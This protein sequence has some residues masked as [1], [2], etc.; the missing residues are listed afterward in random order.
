MVL[1][2]RSVLGTST[3]Y[4]WRC[5][6]VCLSVAKLYRCV[7]EISMKAEFKDGCDLSTGAGSVGVQSGE[8]CHR[9]SV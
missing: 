3:K 4:V 6:H 2:T 8:L 1:I 7:V 5:L 9:D